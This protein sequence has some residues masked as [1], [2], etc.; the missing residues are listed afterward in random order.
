MAEDTGSEFRKD[1]L[2]E[3]FRLLYPILHQVHHKQ[4]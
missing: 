4:V 1:V 2:G 3:S